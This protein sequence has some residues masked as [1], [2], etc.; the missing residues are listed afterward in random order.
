MSV[1]QALTITS[2]AEC[3]AGEIELPINKKASIWF[4]TE[5]VTLPHMCATADCSISV[6]FTV[7]YGINTRLEITAKFFYFQRTIDFEV[8]FSEN[9]P[10]EAQDP[11]EQTS[12]KSQRDSKSAHC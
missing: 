5:M 12:V 3:G 8:F 9:P 4:N 11:D 1:Q 6:A 7:T 10:T 2:I